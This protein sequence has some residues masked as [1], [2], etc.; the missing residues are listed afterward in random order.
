MNVQNYGLEELTL[1]DYE[2]VVG[3]GFIKDFFETY[4]KTV[5][6]FYKGIYDGFM[7]NEKIA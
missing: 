4:Y 3:G 5:G 6:S 1:T 7:G 2:N